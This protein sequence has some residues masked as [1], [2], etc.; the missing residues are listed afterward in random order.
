MLSI[1][2]LPSS[3]LQPNLFISA[4]KIETSKISLYLHAYVYAL[5]VFF[6]PHII[7]MYA[8]QYYT[9]IIF[10]LN[11]QSQYLQHKANILSSKFSPKQ[12]IICCGPWHSIIYSSFQVEVIHSIWPWAIK[13]PIS[14]PSTKQC[15]APHSVLLLT[16][17]HKSPHPL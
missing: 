1:S 10:Q 3:C 16:W 14:F 8:F 7:Y 5:L 15:P 12:S 2:I 4:V 6:F 17:Q 9:L 11:V 13:W